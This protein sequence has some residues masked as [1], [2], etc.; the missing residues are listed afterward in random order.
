MLEVIFG[1][2]LVEDF[3][4]GKGDGN[5]GISGRGIGVIVDVGDVR[6]VWGESFENV[7]VIV[8]IESDG[9]SQCFSPYLTLPTYFVFKIMYIE[10]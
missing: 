1:F 4:S 9:V 8:E 2:K 5:F 6:V 7:V 3:E 10:K